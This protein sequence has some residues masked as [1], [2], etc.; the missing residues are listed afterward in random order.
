MRLLIA[1]LCLSLIACSK[2]ATDSS[3]SSEVVPLATPTPTPEPTPTPALK[4]TTP[5]E[6]KAWLDGKFTQKN[7][8]NNSYLFNQNDITYRAPENCSTH[9]QWVVIGSF[10]GWL[11]RTCNWNS[12][13]IEIKLHPSYPDNYI[14]YTKVLQSN[15]GNT[16]NCMNMLL[17]QHVE[18]EIIDAK[19][20]AADADMPSNPRPI[21]CKD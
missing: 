7:D 13:G 14:V 21:Y 1:L 19:C 2:S 9:Q 6:V 16:T 10:K 20:F 3:E 8:A 17:E 5:E 18:I 12:T 15:G 4:P 11:N